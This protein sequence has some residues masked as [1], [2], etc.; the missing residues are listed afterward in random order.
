MLTPQQSPMQV[1][2]PPLPQPIFPTEEQEVATQNTGNSVNDR[3][4]N[5]VTASVQ[6]KS[7][8]SSSCS[9]SDSESE[10]HKKRPR[11]A[12]RSKL[13]VRGKKQES[14]ESDKNDSAES[15]SDKEPPHKHLKRS[16]PKTIKT[17]GVST[18]VPTEELPIEQPTSVKRAQ[19]SEHLEHSVVKKKTPVVV[20]K[21]NLRER[22]RTYAPTPSR[23]TK[24]KD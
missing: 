14:S 24:K 20:S 16:Q 7:S 17:R 6:K 12:V 19:K 18:P 21:Y 1:H 3:N 23:K 22:A 13:A 11:K 8:S 5:A 15:E 10:V 4:G 2:P 9:S